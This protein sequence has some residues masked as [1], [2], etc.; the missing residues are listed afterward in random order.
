MQLREATKSVKNHALAVT[1][2]GNYLRDVHDG[3]LAGRYDLKGLSAEIP[4]GGHARRIMA[5]YVRWLEDYNRHAEL[6]ILSIIGLFDRPA[7]PE[8]MEALLIDREFD[9]FT[10][11][12][13]RVGSP[14]WHRCVEA[15]RGMGLLNG[16]IP[17]WPGT[18]DAHPLVREHFRDELQSDPAMWISGNEKLYK[19]YGECASWQPE[20]SGGMGELYAGVNHGCA[21]NLHQRVFDEILLTRV[22]RDRRQSYSTRRLGMTGSDLVALSNYFRPRQWRALRDLEINDHARVLIMT[23]AGVRLRQLGRLSDARE[24]FG[25]VIK[26]IN[27]STASAEE[28]NDAAYA[29]GQRCELLVIS[30]SLDSSSGEEGTALSSGMQAVVFGDRGSDQYFKMHSRSSL[31]EVYFM[32]GDCDEAGRLFEEARN[33]E[34]AIPPFLYSQGLFRY[35][36][37]LIETGHVDQLVEDQRTVPGWGTNGKDSSLLSK[38]IRF[39]IEGAALRAMIEAGDSRKGVYVNARQ[40]LDK[41]VIAF[42]DAGY[43]DYLVRGLLSALTSSV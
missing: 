1:L 23:N 33:I 26:A 11:A 35:G 32:L 4:E 41:A 6:A 10:T 17:D 28:F 2:L 39:L 30:G 18:L 5:S 43:S 14:L 16:E 31:A 19:Y 37:Y 38:A 21:A 42:R 13:E 36:Y 40:T 8:A 20:T 25:A 22:W 7:P 9:P 27:E 12:H 3:D 15:L 29:A 34:G 24:C